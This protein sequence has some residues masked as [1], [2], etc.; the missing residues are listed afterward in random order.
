MGHMI[1]DEFEHCGG[2]LRHDDRNWNADRP[3]AA[4]NADDGEKLFYTDIS[5]TENV[6]LAGLPAFHCKKQTHCDVA[7]VDKVHDE[8]QINL[9]PSP[10]KILQHKS[11]RRETPV[12]WSDRHRRISNDHG[13]A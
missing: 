5:A 4:D 13:K 2:C 3:A 9:N 12:V 8:I 11:R 7:D 6:A 1:G 10:Q